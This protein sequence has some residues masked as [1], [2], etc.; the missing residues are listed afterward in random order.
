MGSTLA[1]GGFINNAILSALRVLYLCSFGLLLVQ[2]E[3]E[4]PAKLVSN[5]HL[6]AQSGSHNAGILPPHIHISDIRHE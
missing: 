2:R 5:A 6:L 4:R 3:L 1:Y